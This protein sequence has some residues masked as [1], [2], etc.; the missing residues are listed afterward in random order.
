[1]V[2]GVMPFFSEELL[3]VR[4]LAHERRGLEQAG[5]EGRLVFGEQLGARGL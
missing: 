3:A 5:H 2:S 1:M 4:H